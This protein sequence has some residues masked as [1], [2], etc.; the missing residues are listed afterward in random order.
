MQLRYGW[1]R[2]KAWWSHRS[3]TERLAIS[4]QGIIMLATVSYVTVASFQWWQM[5]QSNETA[6][7]ALISVQRAFV[8]WTGFSIQ[9]V[10]KRL[11]SGD[12]R[13]LD[14]VNSW[15]NSG[16]TPAAGVVH[17][18][19]IDKLSAEPSE[20]QFIGVTKSA[21]TTY[22]GPKGQISAIDEK[23]QTFYIG[24]KPFTTTT[25]TRSKYSLLGLDSLSRR[26][27]RH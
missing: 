22:I 20:Q 15:Q 19:H 3:G 23:P 6:E 18:F 8:Q 17:Y 25:S 1:N 10:V 27:R 14:I 9:G 7:Q 12:E 5:R 24:T 11:P 21:Y 16:T 4:F 13:S 2:A 26:F